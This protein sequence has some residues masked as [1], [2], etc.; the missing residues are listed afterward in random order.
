MVVFEREL[1]LLLT[2]SSVRFGLHDPADAS[3]QHPL[4][5]SL[6]VMSFHRSRKRGNSWAWNK[7]RVG[8]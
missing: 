8:L 7:F 6:Q 2:V 5:H 1:W 3:E 4:R